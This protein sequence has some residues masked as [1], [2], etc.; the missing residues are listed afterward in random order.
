MS[1]RNH[2]IMSN[3]FKGIIILVIILISGMCQKRLD[4]KMT[5]SCFDQIY[6]VLNEPLRKNLNSSQS[7]KWCQV[8][9][10]L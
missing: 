8:F 5:Q 4:P 2:N 7:T 6:Q 3:V 1:G 9:M 10:I